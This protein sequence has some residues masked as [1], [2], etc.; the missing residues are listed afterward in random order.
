[1]LATLAE[2]VATPTPTSQYY[3]RSDG[4]GT[5]LTADSPSALRTALSKAGPGSTIWLRGGTYNDGEVTLPSSGSPGTPLVIRNYASET[6]TFDGIDPDP[7]T[8]TAQG[9][10]VY[11]T[12]VRC[13]DP[14]LVLLGSGRMYAYHALSDLQNLKWGPGFFATGTTLYVRL[15]GDADPSTAFVRASRFNRGYRTPL[16]AWR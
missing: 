12:T 13:Q 6:V 8:W 4:T 11:R 15:P 2:P 14:H 3:V 5:C 10:G 7:F 9:G 16:G 1:M